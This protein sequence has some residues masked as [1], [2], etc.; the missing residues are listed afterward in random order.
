M[1]L[2]STLNLNAALLMTQQPDQC[3]EWKCIVNCFKLV[4]YN[5]TCSSLDPLSC[6]RLFLQVT[7]KQ[8][9][10]QDFPGIDNNVFSE[11]FK[12]CV[13]SSCTSWSIVF[14]SQRL[15]KSSI[16]WYWKNHFTNLKKDKSDNPIAQR[17]PVSELQ[18]KTGRLLKVTVKRTRG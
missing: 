3:H 17:L 10:Q 8:Q 15:K 13:V 2:P 7:G 18:V 5:C 1:Y 11:F 16:S 6:S 9:G 12:G 14:Q 4:L